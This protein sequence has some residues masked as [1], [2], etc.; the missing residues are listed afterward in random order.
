LLLARL[1]ADK[2]LITPFGPLRFLSER[3]LLFS[4]CLS[5]LPPNLGNE[6]NSA[7]VFKKQ[8]RGLEGKCTKVAVL[9]ENEK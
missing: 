6:K 2:S 8:N 5:P 3:L 4:A 9:E 1:I 7:G